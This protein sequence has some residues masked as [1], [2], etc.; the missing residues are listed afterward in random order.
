MKNAI[1]EKQSRHSRSSREFAKL[2]WKN[3]LNV[4]FWYHP[5]VYGSLL[6]VAE[7]ANFEKVVIEKQAAPLFQTT[8]N[9]ENKYIY[10]YYNS[11]DKITKKIQGY[12]S[13]LRSSYFF[14]FKTCVKIRIKIST[15]ILCSKKYH[16]Q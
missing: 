14:S 12:Y 9:L 15:Q 8:Q 2:K 3:K 13:T 5:T 10:R 4:L 16:S 6:R 7:V 11:N 1:R